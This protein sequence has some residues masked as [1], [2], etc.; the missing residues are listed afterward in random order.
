MY[1]ST[2]I[3]KRIKLIAKKNGISIGKM[4]SSCN[5][6][7]NTISHMRQGTMPKSDT[8]A[9]IAD[10]LNCSVDYLLGRTNDTELHQK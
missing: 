2:N 6:G 3:A 1:N 10:I 8:L 5:L 9:K 7:I 4:L